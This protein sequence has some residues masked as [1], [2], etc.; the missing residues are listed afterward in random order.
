MLVPVPVLRLRHV[1]VVLALGLAPF[2]ALAD[3]HIG[4]ILSTTGPAAP[5]PVSH[6]TR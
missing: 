6:P 2:A 1:L 3:I 4:V 5:L